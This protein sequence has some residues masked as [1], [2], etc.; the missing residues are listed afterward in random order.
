MMLGGDEFGRTQYGN[1]NAYCQDNETSWVDWSLATRNRPLSDFVRRLTALRKTYAVLRKT[2]FLSGVRNDSVG[3]RDVTW[4][5]PSGREMTQEDWNNA[6][7][8]CFGMMIDG[9]A[10]P[11]PPE[12]E[13]WNAVIFLLLNDA[14]ADTSF[15]LPSSAGAKR[16][17]LLLDS[18]QS[19]GGASEKYFQPGETITAASRTFLVLL[20]ERS[21]GGREDA[22]MPIEP[23]LVEQA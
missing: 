1:N 14:P 9:R 21:D 8:R 19:D 13:N 17:K 15:V 16:W 4:I 12:I 11:M 5:L 6:A 22:T 18:S 3:V 23:A 20:L 10:R 7:N 2:R